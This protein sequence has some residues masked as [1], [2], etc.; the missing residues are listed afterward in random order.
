MKLLKIFVTLIIFI[1]ILIIP[2]SIFLIKF[3]NKSALGGFVKGQ[4]MKYPRLISLMNLNEPGDNRFLYLGQKSQQ[5]KVNIYSVN[6]AR[7]NEKVGE[8][9]NEIIFETTGKR[10]VVSDLGSINYK[11]DGL[12]SDD[13]LNNIRKLL[14]SEMGTPSDLNIVYT[15]SYSEKPSSIGLV[16]HRDTVYIFNDALKKL[17]EKS[18]VN[19][20][21]EKTTIMHE[22]GHLLGVDHILNDDCVMSEVVEV[23]DNPSYGKSLPTKYC[24]EELEAIKIIK[25]GI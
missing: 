6:N 21:L 18:A 14:I 11:N 8:W 3:G 17:S 12:L 23:Y 2:L 9:I 15:S 10:A 22:W 25:K 19:N 7:S 24:W 16:I 20:I 4:V 13:D 5:I 1:F